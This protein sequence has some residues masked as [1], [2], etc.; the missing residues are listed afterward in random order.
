MAKAL[1]RL[2]K[3]SDLRSRLGKNARQRA[4]EF[5]SWDKLGNRLAT[6]YEKSTV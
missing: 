1:E 3:D 2:Y 5:Y 4:E 6:L